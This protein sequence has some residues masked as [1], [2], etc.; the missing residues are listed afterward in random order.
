MKVITYPRGC[1]KVH[2]K[3]DIGKSRHAG[4]A[5]EHRQREPTIGPVR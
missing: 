2:E 1:D 3:P 5:P 4:K